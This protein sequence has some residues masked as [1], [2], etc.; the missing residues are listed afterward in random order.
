[1]DAVEV[2]QGYADRLKKADK[3]LGTLERRARKLAEKQAEVDSQRAELEA[4]Q[5]AAEQ[6]VEA[7]EAE[8]SELKPELLEAMMR[9]DAA[10]QRE[11]KQRR[12]A[13]ADEVRKHQQEL[14]QLRTS[15][16]ALDDLQRE[17][18]E[19]AIE[20]DRL[21][22]GNWWLFHDELRQILRTNA[23]SLKNRQSGARRALPKF[24]SSTYER[25]RLDMDEEY[26]KA[27]QHREEQGRQLQQRLERNRKELENANKP[28]RGVGRFDGAVRAMSPT[29]A[30]RS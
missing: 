12:K 11:L 19:L 2:L 6:A 24:D 29:A 13:I 16:D 14:E 22:F 3:Q 4:K 18:A 5:A 30:D 15:L 7:L 27:K 8:D 21:E 17:S 20:L 26:Q 9:D 23:V 1:M 28:H 25:M 10:E